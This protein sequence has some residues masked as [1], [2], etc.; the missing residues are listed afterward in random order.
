MSIIPRLDQQF[1]RRQWLVSAGRLSAAGLIGSGLFPV[2]AVADKKKPSLFGPPPE[3]L[4]TSR[5]QSYR[6]GVEVTAVGG[7]LARLYATLPV[8]VEWPEQTLRLDEEEYTPHIKNVSFRELDHRVRQMVVTIP[9]V[10]ADETARAMLHLKIDRSTILP[11]ENPEEYMSLKRVP[12]EAKGMV[13]TSPLIET[14]HTKMRNQ[15]KVWIRE[16]LAGWE[17]VETIYDWVQQNI[18]PVEGVKPRGALQALESKQGHH[19]DVT[20][21][22]VAL[23]RAAKVPARMVFLP[24][25]TY[26]EFMLANA[27][28]EPEWLPCRVVGQKEIGGISEYRPILQKGDKIRV[29][30]KKEPQRFVADSLRGQKVRGGGKP[31]VRFIREAN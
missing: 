14:R 27:E 8:P 28:G 2:A 6:V 18:Q 16:K 21:L 23:C 4:G 5:T 12:K 3:R 26:A 19:E 29:P 1:D 22:F 15:A 11:P 10:P 17:L 25:M 31:R 7:P 13:G 9:S 30:E 20:G 24:K